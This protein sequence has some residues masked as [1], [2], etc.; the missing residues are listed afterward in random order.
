MHIKFYKKGKEGKV[1]SEKGGKTF[2]EKDMNYYQ[3]Y[4]LNEDNKLN[5]LPAVR[6][7]ILLP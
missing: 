3:T 4:L 1:M 5:L 6:N 7:S 2:K